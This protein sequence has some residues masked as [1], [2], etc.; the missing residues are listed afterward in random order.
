MHICL[1]YVVYIIDQIKYK[2][3]SMISYRGTAGAPFAQIIKVPLS[4][5]EKVYA[6]TPRAWERKKG[7]TCF[8]LLHCESFIKFCFFKNDF[9]NASS[10]SEKYYD[11]LQNKEVFGLADYVAL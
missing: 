5:Y 3:K 1:R 2:L 9:Q 7:K 8:V 10:E 4:Q 11:F 6:R